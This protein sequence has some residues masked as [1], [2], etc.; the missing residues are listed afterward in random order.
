MSNSTCV[1]PEFPTRMAGGDGGARRRAQP[2]GAG[3]FRRSQALTSRAGRFFFESFSR[4]ILL[5]E[6]DVFP[7]T[8][9]HFSASCSKGSRRTRDARAVSKQ[10]WRCLD[11]RSAD[12]HGTSICLPSAEL[13]LRGKEK[14]HR[15]RAVSGKQAR[16][17]TGSAFEAH[18][19]A[20]RSGHAACNAGSTVRPLLLTSPT[21]CAG[22]CVVSRGAVSAGAPARGSR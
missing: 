15:N 17:R 6:H 8:G 4:S 14:L 16:S 20:D 21:A 7:K 9:S 2:C 13:G 18:S 5:S 22:A 3:T 12:G 19:R 11:P 1:K 10:Q